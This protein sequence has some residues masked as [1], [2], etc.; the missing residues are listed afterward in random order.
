MTQSLA[1]FPAG[2]PVSLGPMESKKVCARSQVREL[3]MPSLHMR[4]STGS[5]TPV[6]DTSD[7]H[8]MT[9]ATKARISLRFMGLAPV[10]YARP[11]LPSGEKRRETR[12][13]GP[14]AANGERRKPDADYGT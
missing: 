12:E 9:V 1:A 13:R 6:W 3:S 8:G 11:K 5:V 4:L 2:V 14:R 7:A 10:T